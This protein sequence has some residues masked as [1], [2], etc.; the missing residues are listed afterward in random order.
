MPPACGHR[1][2]H[3]HGCRQ[4]GP[5]FGVS[6]GFYMEGDVSVVLPATRP[7]TVTPPDFQPIE[8]HVHDW[9]CIP[10]YENCD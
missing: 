3:K 6:L 1:E 8:L 7:G 9:I 4:S 2:F 5:C 10:R